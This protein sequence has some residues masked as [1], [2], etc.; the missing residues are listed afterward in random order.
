MDFS[1]NGEPVVIE[2]QRGA[3]TDGDSVVWF[4]R[5]DVLSVGDLIRVDAYPVVDVERGG[6]INGLVAALDRILEI[7]VPARLQDGGTRVIPGHGRLLNEADVV[8]YRDMVTIIRDRVQDFITRGM[9]LEQVRTARPSRDYDTRYGP[10]E[11]FVEAAY[12][13]LGRRGTE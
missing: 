10:G 2:H 7:T 8:E 5:S 12:R 9:S 11:T 1:F 4:R 6:T 3:H 13:T